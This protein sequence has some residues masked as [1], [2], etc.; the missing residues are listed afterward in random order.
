MNMA[1][2]CYQACRLVLFIDNLH[3]SYGHAI[4]G[5]VVVAVE[6]ARFTFNTTQQGTD[7]QGAKLIWHMLQARNLTTRL[8]GLA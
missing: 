3:T 7:M 4:R 6:M 5:L 8:G 2:V 1:C